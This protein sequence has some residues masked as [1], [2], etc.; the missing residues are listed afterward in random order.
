MI[1]IKKTRLFYIYLNADSVIS[2]KC[3]IFALG[4]G[5]IRVIPET[6]I[7]MSIDCKFLT[8]LRRKSKNDLVKS[9]FACAAV[10]VKAS[11]PQFTTDKEVETA[12][13]LFIEDTFS[14]GWK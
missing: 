3:C 1:Y 10:A 5:N 14:T 9:L 6:I 4:I 8:K 11:N 7:V 12:V 2:K 13:E